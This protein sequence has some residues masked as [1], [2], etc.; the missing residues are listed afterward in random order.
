[1]YILVCDLY[2]IFFYI[3]IFK[4]IINTEILVIMLVL[5]SQNSGLT[6]KVPVMSSISCILPTASK[7]ILLN[8]L[9]YSDKSFQWIL[10]DFGKSAYS[11][12]DCTLY[13]S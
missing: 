2:L 9:F 3:S 6:C 12:A 10:F 1:M 8:R 4:K 5:S 11:W 7:L 13:N